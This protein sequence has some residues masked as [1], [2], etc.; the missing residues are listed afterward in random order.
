[1]TNRTLISLVL[2]LLLALV[3]FYIALPIQHPQAVANL[4]FWQPRGFRSLELKLGLDLQGGLQVLLAADLP[5]GQ[6]PEAQAMEAAK[7]VV[8]NRVNGLGVA[9]PLVQRQGEDRIIVELPGIQN[10]DQ[11]IATL[12]GTGL[13]EFI[14]AG[15]VP[16]TPG[17]IVQ[18]DFGGNTEGDP[19]AEGILNP[20]TGKP[21]RTIMTGADLRSAQVGS[22]PTTGLPVILFE[23]NDSG[24][25]IFRE[26]TRNNIGRIV[27]ITMDK[28]VLSAP[29][30]RAVI[31]G[32]GEISGQF[33]R[34]EARTLAIQMQYGALPV[35][36]KVLDV[37]TVGASLG[38][39][40]VQR[41]LTAGIIGLIV[42]LLF[43]AIYYRVP[44]LLA[45]LALLIFVA[46]NITLFKIVPITLTLPGIAG[47]LLA[48]GTAVDANVLV[49]ERMKEELRNGKPLKA[50]VEAGFNRAWTSILDSNLSTLITCMILYYFGG[51]FGASTVRGFA[52]TL[53]LGILTSM[54]TAVFVT[55]TFMRATFERPGMDEKVASRAWI[56]GV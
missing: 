42:V 23:L 37:R 6:R 52:F 8:D 19:N 21:F 5:E 16:L 3:T 54:F 11:A 34:E 13:L 40:S 36:L 9:E 48:T 29:V 46:I 14:E 55:R 43:M 53:F 44:G 39:D 24:R 50:A 10:P 28:Q 18:T 56:L 17:T 38:A 27:A 7:I 41:S 12:K 15:N 1:M 47:F 45:D 49:F 35:P 32:S 26:Y 20:E 51:T 33:T 25:E 2:I 31:D 22:D 4:A 30:V